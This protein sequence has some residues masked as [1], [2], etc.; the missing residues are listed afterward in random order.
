M[1]YRC[2][3]AE[4][5]LSVYHVPAWVARR[6]LGIGRCGVWAVAL[7]FEDAS[8]CTVLI[9]AKLMPIRHTLARSGPSISNLRRKSTGGC[10]G[11]TSCPACPATGS[12]CMAPLLLVPDGKVCLKSVSSQSI[13]VA[14]SQQ[15]SGCQNID[16]MSTLCDTWDI[17]L[18]T[19]AIDSNICCRTM[20]WYGKDYCA[21]LQP[22]GRGH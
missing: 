22:S 3:T 14:G 6:A 15:I 11:L 20:S 21:P 4:L 9:S 5:P 8:V 17:P 19:H 7:A 18:N 16:L 13:T 12:A 1:T 10:E 2:K